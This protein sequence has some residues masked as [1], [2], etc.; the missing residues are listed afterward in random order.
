[1]FRK[2][3]DGTST[4]YGGNMCLCAIVGSADKS[5]LNQSQ[6]YTTLCLALSVL[7]DFSAFDGFLDLRNLFV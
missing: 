2:K 1:M 5:L 6:T 3:S 7:V 4:Y